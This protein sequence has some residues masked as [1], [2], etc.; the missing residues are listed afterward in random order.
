MILVLLV[1]AWAVFD[2]HQKSRRF[3]DSRLRD[4]L[5]YL[6][7]FNVIELEAFLLI[8]FDSNLTPLQSQSFF[9]G[10]RASIGRSGR[11]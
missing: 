9:P 8:Y 6:V 7:V 1:G 4:L 3:P 5:R 2:V 10:S 11:C